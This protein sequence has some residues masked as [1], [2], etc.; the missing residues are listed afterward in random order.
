MHRSVVLGLFFLILYYACAM[1]ETWVARAYTSQVVQFT[2][3]EKYKKYTRIVFDTAPTGHTLR[4]LALP[5]FLDKSIGKASRARFVAYRQFLGSC[6]VGQQNCPHS[7]REVGAAALPLWTLPC[8]VKQAGPVH[9]AGMQ[10]QPITK[11]GLFL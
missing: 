5:D 10:R 1:R 8:S 9:D 6:V 2:K 4:L 7:R 3:E 11:A